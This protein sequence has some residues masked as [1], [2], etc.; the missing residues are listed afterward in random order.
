MD[1]KSFARE[2]LLHRGLGYASNRASPDSVAME[3]PLRPQSHDGFRS[4]GDSALAVK[5]GG[6]ATGSSEG[7]CGVDGVHIV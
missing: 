4:G 2:R 6:A 1:S 5:G 7:G 3:S